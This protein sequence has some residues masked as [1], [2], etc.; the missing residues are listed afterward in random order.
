MPGWLLLAHQV[1]IHVTLQLDL[2]YHGELLISHHLLHSLMDLL[3]SSPL[4]PVWQESFHHLVQDLR[5]DEQSGET[6]RHTKTPT[7]AALSNIILW[8][9]LRAEEKNRKEFNK[10]NKIFNYTVFFPYR[11]YCIWG[12]GKSSIKCTLS[13]D[14]T[15]IY[16]NIII[17]NM[18][19][20]TAKL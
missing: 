13:L 14:A 19:L 3:I 12:N 8:H 6:L 7:K 4:Q 10:P 11:S 20:K 1:S 2:L 16:N 9:E 15:D 18:P 17:R 5:G